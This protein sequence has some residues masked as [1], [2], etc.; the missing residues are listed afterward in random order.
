[1]PH[2]DVVESPPSASAV[3]PAA[4]RSSDEAPV[5]RSAAVVVVSDRAA[6]GT[7]PDSVGPQLCKMLEAAGFE[8]RSV[9]VVPDA[10]DAIVAAL[11]RYTTDASPA[12][13]VVTTGGTGLGPRDVTPE[14][15]RSIADK[16][17]E[18]LAEAMRLKG[19]AS[20]PLA[21]LSRQVAAVVGSSL[22][23][24]LP[25]S[26]RGAVESLSAVLPTLR[27]ALAMLR[28][29]TD[30]SHHATET[31]DALR[32]EHETHTSHLDVQTLSDSVCLVSGVV[33]N[34]L[35]S[36]ELLQHIRKPHCGGMVAFEGVARSPSDGHQVAFL[37]YDCYRRLAERQ[38]REI[39]E[40]AVSRYGLGGA[41]AVHRV[42]K[43][44][45]G[46]TIVIAAAAAPHREAAFDAAHEI[47]ERIKA[48]AAIWKKEVFADERHHRWVGSESLFDRPDAGQ[49][50]TSS[51]G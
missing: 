37:E 5:S 6:S 9:T 29:A 32:G 26:P 44:Y 50:T 4:S 22:V 49:D 43:V 39:A 31:D 1:M 14:A 10:V 30:H 19:L 17:V 24:A 23:L 46:E 16:E 41:V 51:G 28:G 2:R 33:E 15:V 35:D 3:E 36:R 12:D 7:R 42:G 20:T 47:I 40:E 45:P 27:H 38:L 21:A 34:Q 13:L 11:R 8:V 48:E 25:G 18:G